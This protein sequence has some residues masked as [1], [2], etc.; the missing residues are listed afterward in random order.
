MKIVCPHCHNEFELKDAE[1]QDILSQVRNNEFKE[2]LHSRLAQYEEKT[3]A[4]QELLLAK[5][6]E[7]WLNEVNRLKGQLS[8]YDK[9]KELA[10][11]KLTEKSRDELTKKDSEIAALKAKLEKESLLAEA[12]KK[13]SLEKLQK[14]KDQLQNDLLLKDKNFELEKKNLE[15][16]HKLAIKQLEEELAFYK[17]FKA[18]E[19]TKMV[20]EDLE[21]YCHERFESVRSMAF[22]NAYFEKDNDIKSGS[23][24]DFIFRDYEDGLE[25]ISIMFEMKNESDT[26]GTKHKNEDFLKELD[27][28]RNEKKC[29][30]AVLVSMLERDSDLYNQGIV[31]VSHRYPKMYVIRPQF[32]LP[33]I[34]LLRNEARNSLKYRRE[35]VALRNQNLDIEHFEDNLQAFKDDF[36]KN[37]EKAKGKF[38][39]AIA[40]I[41]KTI[42][43]LTKI[44]EELTGSERQLGYANDKIDRITIRRLTKDAPSVAAAFKDLK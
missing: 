27:K 18:K 8:S 28:D 1:Y 33:L 21:K 25:Y 11:A 41:D 6:K 42:L 5:K 19:S 23:K 26:L 35:V 20:G 10:L 34:S 39:K 16:S 2:E 13:E 7:E 38:D 14:D 9:D 37:F 3:K 12:A 15:E 17:D 30:Y 4:E 31:D 36:S 44:K 29:E 22:P 24:G 32:F 43:S 40:E